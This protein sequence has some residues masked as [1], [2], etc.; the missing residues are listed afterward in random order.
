ML[1]VVVNA[2][3]AVLLDR[4]TPGSSRVL[5]RPGLLVAGAVG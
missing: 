2:V 5:D 3:V 4:D 1:A